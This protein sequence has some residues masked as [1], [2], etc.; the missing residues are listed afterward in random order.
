MRKNV[1]SIVSDLEPLQSRCAIVKFSKLSDEDVLRRLIF[2]CGEEKVEYTNDGLKALLYTAQGDM[3]QVI[4]TLSS[5]KCLQVSCSFSGP[6]QPTVHCSRLRTRDEGGSL[7][8]LR[9]ATPG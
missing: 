6:Q 4:G 8:D 2:V 1:P 3:R 5:C 7:Q 9:R